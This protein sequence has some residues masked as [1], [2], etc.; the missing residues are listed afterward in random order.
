[1][2]QPRLPSIPNESQQDRL[3]RNVSEWTTYLSTKLKVRKFVK[4]LNKH[5]TQAVCT[6]QSCAGSD[7]RCVCLQPI[8]HYGFIPCIV[9]L[10]MT[11]TEPKP[12]WPQL[13]GPM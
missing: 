11:Q 1:M 2:A 7:T 3:V 6:Q 10:G 13:L 8:V 9:I 5:F 12:T 4:E